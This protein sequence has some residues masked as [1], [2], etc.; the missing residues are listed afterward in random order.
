[1]RT[2][3]ELREYAARKLAKE[4]ALFWMP[5]RSQ[6][7]GVKIFQI[8]FVILVLG[9]MLGIPLMVFGAG[10]G[11]SL[12][13]PSISALTPEKMKE[14]LESLKGVLRT[15][16]AFFQAQMLLT[17]SAFAD[18]LSAAEVDSALAADVVSDPLSDQRF[19]TS[20]L[21]E[22]DCGGYLPRNRSIW[23]LR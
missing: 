10:N 19:D 8:I 13:Q 11:P 6:P 4:R 21:T 2:D 22:H 14:R 5:W 12:D 17:E 23:P 7:L 1:P 15:N 16:A 18:S 3:E 20:A 9:I